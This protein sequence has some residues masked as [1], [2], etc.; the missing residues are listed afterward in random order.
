MCELSIITFFLILILYL[1][2]LLIRVKPKTTARNTQTQDACKTD[3][4]ANCVVHLDNPSDNCKLD[5]TKILNMA[6]SSSNCMEQTRFKVIV[7]RDRRARL[8]SGYFP[9][10]PVYLHTKQTQILSFNIHTGIYIDA[11]RI[12]ENRAVLYIYN[13]TSTSFIVSLLMPEKDTGV[14]NDEASPTMRLCNYQGQD[15]YVIIRPTQQRSVDNEMVVL[16]V[17]KSWYRYT[18]S[19]SPNCNDQAI[20]VLLD[21][22]QVSVE[23]DDNKA[24]RVRKMGLFD[25]ECDYK[26]V[27]MGKRKLGKSR[28]CKPISYTNKLLQLAVPHPTL[29]F[30]CVNG[31]KSSSDFLETVK[32]LLEGETK[33]VYLNL[34]NFCYFLLGAF[35]NETGYDKDLLKQ[36]PTTRTIMIKYAIDMVSLIFYQDEQIANIEERISENEEGFM[37]LVNRNLMLPDGAIT[38]DYSPFFE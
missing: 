30:K 2:L 6:A 14:P 22:L 12:D 31:A 38:F 4:D 33:D 29:L 5:Q 11:E 36:T 26:K 24:H 21:P 32:P 23:K 27:V 15:G 35:L 20:L 7:S 17:E 18:I 13:D 19:V 8:E 3:E 25:I 9:G 16:L 28:I 34:V 1:Y 10:P 37:K